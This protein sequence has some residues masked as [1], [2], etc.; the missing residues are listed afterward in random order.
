ML[1]RELKPSTRGASSQIRRAG[2]SWKRQVVSQ[3]DVA[4][5]TRQD[6]V[7]AETLPLF[8]TFFSS[9]IRFG[10]TVIA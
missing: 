5:K 7:S 8:V 3:R 9:F 1:E 4:E 6:T 10:H 2:R